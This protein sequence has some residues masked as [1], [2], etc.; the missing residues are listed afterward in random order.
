MLLW[1]FFFFWTQC[2]YDVILQLTA[3]HLPQERTK[4]P[5]FF[6]LATPQWIFNNSILNFHNNISR[7]IHKSH[8]PSGYKINFFMATIVSKIVHSKVKKMNN[9]TNDEINTYCYNIILIPT[10][11]RLP[12]QHLP[13]TQKNSCTNKLS[14]TVNRAN[15]LV[16][17]AEPKCIKAGIVDPQLEAEPSFE[18]SNDFAYY[19]G[20]QC[21]FAIYTGL[22]LWERREDW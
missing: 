22:N 14:H 8:G 17:E 9:Y 16:I 3:E 4:S 1:C 11:Q 6:F 18:T 5:K 20:H 12:L 7:S 10:P 15:R 2:S 19:L 13:V 21:N